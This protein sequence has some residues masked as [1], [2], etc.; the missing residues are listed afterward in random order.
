MTYRHPD[1]TTATALRRT[2]SRLVPLALGAVLVTSTVAVGA[3]ASE[4][5]RGLE[6]TAPQR[7][8]DSRTM[9]GGDKNPPGG[10]IGVVTSEV[11]GDV[12][13][14]EFADPIPD[15]AEAVFVNVTAVEAEAPGFVSVVTGANER[16]DIDFVPDTS[17]LNVDTPGQTIANSA[18]IPLGAVD[19][20]GDFGEQPTVI[21]HSSMDTHVLVDVLG[22]VP[23]G[24][25]YTSIP[26]DRVL[27]TRDTGGAGA[28][29]RFDI[30]AIGTAGPAGA[31]LAIVNLTLV[32]SGGAGFVT[33]WPAGDDKPGT[34]NL[35]VDGVGQTRAG[36]A[37]VPIGADG[38]IS[39]ESSTTGDLLVDVLGYFG[40]Q[41]GF[42][43]L[44]PADR[45][46]DS[47]PSGRVEADSTTAV[48]V[49]SD[50]AVPD[51]AEFALVNVTA[52][53]ASAP[54][55][56]SVWPGGGDRP[57]ASNLNYPAGGTVANTVLVPLGDDGAIDVYTA[58]E[59]DLLVDVIGWL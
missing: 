14:I 4:P 7:Y 50:S 44:E 17:N 8:W 38:E 47:R 58:A 40:E 37:I 32:D 48:A 33:A 49:T 39:V 41:S 57:D 5:P 52:V 19:Y 53:G 56:V 26:L 3:T 13:G 23:A 51:E 10:K 42:N 25:D 45:V 12:M 31:S 15:D 20:G 22:Y 18:I 21:V 6:A 46:L 2:R 30:D 54:G 36:L 59:I 34:S 27:D 11:A 9:F 35:N 28:G 16:L 29:D 55:F 43:G 24:S 1:G